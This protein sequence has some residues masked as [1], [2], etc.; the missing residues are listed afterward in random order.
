MFILEIYNNGYIEINVDNPYITDG[1]INFLLR[2]KAYQFYGE[3]GFCINVIDLKELTHKLNKL[4]KDLTGEVVLAD[5][6]S[7]S[8]ISLKMSENNDVC[9]IGQLGS[10][11]ED[12]IWIFKQD[13]D[14]TIIQLLINCFNNL[15]LLI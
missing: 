5:Y 8:F 13:V 6:D 15:T 10:K 7:E 1:Y 12:N 3:H 14:Q 4:Y 9:L 11:W 2:I